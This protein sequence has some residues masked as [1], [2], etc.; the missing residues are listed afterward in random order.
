[1]SSFVLD[2]FA[3]IAFYLQE[4]GGQQVY[5]LGRDKTHQ[6]WLSVIN[7]GEMYYKLLKVERVNSANAALDN[8]LTWP[9]LNIVDADRAF[10][11]EAARLKAEYPISYADCFAAA[12]A[13]QVDAPVV[14]GDPEFEQLERDGIVAIEWLA[15]KRKRSRRR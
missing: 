12:L 1:L 9:R 7:L 15:P 14:T 4:P 8:L 10:T 13:R 11:L 6:L 5:T 2:S 3:L